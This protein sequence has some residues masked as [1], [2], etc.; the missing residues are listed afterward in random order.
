MNPAVLF[1]VRFFLP[2]LAGQIALEPSVVKL[3]RR[4]GLELWTVRA[5]EASAKAL[6]ER[7][8]ELAQYG[9]DATSALD[10]APLVTI[11]LDK[12]PLEQ[13]LEFALGSAGLLVEV[14]DATIH[15][16]ADRGA[17]ETPDQRAGLAAAAWARA[18]A[19]H[20]RHPVAATARLAQG[21]LEELRGHVAPGTL[22]ITVAAVASATIG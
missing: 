22:A 14:S 5:R 15:V 6:L 21:E 3:E 17:D 4:D 13:V 19:Q 2:A 7:V 16:R 8:A 11:A 18:A 1:A 12:R 20:P 10:R 9:I